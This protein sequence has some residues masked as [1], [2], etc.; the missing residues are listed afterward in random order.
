MTIHEGDVSFTPVEAADLIGTVTAVPQALDNQWFDRELLGE[1]LQVGTVDKSVL[2]R[3]DGK[4]RIEYLR[5]LLA[6]EKIIVNR[7]YLY[8]N[9]VVF[10]DYRTPGPDREAFRDL[11]REGA[12]LPWL[13]GEP[14]PV[15]ELD[16]D[17]E[18]ADG[19]TAWR[20][21]AE[22]TA[23]SCVRLSWDEEE[24]AR[25]SRE[26]FREFGRF[27]LDFTQLDVKALQRDL[28][29]RDEAHAESVLKRLR[30]V[31]RWVHDQLDAD[32]LVTRQQLYERFVVADGKPVTEYHFDAAKPH[33]AQVKQ[34]L[35]L[36]YATN[37]ADAVDVFSIT[38]GDS[39]RR[40]AL[41]EGLAALRGRGRGDLGDTDSDQLITL[42][43]NLA[44]ENVQELLEAVPT[45]DRLSLADVH[46]VRRERE[47]D[48]YRRLFSALVNSSSVETLTDSDQGAEAIT[49][50]YLTMLRKAEEISIRRRSDAYFER[51][52]GLTQIG[53]DVGS[54]TVNAFFLNGHAPAFE[55]IGDALGMA[56]SR[57]AKVTIRWGVGRVLGR[58][59]RRRIDNTAQILTLRMEN[60]RREAKRLLDFVTGRTQLPPD[61]GNGQDISDE[62]E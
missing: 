19:L 41:Q 59:G 51:F 22:S 35:D 25:L 32:R 31:S 12:I 1:A 29:L 53:I 36:K 47:W 55:V 33:A 37:L 3:R 54:L 18:T 7:A 23:M 8:N 42:L 44:F 24:N 48:T 56:G 45:L 43:R 50:A 10:R 30:E 40:T 62:D 21:V 13:L 46:D 26:M 4:A 15:P 28:A 49:K 17:F 57:A 27:A 14:S 34:L 52:N 9:P 38:P 16:P 5:A 61:S 58:G 20:E 2:A 39:P 6:T 60:P 11:L